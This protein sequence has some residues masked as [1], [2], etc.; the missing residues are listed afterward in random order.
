M[1]ASATMNAGIRR[2]VGIGDDGCGNSSGGGDRRRWLL[3]IV[4]RRDVIDCS[5]M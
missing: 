3:E 4:E 1:W 2:D 5:E